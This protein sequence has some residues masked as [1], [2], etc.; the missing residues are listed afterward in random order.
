[1]I[2]KIPENAKYLIGVLKEKGFEAFVVGGC[3]R[4]CILGKPPKDW[5][6]CTSALPEQVMYCFQNH[7][8]IETG[9]KHGT[10]TIVIDKEPYEVTTYR[11]DGEYSDNRRPDS[12]SFTSSLI[13]DL[14]RRDF[15]INAMA[16]N[17]ESGLQ[18]PFGGSKDIAAGRIQCVGDADKR[19]Q[20]DALRIM[21]AVRFASQLEFEIAH[22]TQLAM[23]RNKSLLQKISVERIS[24]ELNKLLC[25]KGVANV[26]K[27]YPQIIGEAIPEIFPMVGFEQ[28]NPYHIYD[29]WGHTVT[30]IN[31][32][33]DDLVLRLT[34]F[35]HDIGKPDCFSVDSG[36]IG[37]FYGHEE[38]S[39]MI[40][41]EVMKRLRYNNQTIN[42]VVMLIKN[43]DIR[44]TV[45]RK[46]AKKML[47]KLGEEK[48]HL[49]TEVRIAD[50]T[51]QSQV[52]QDARVQKVDSFR[53]VIK[54]VMSQ[55]QC[56]SLTDLA[57]NGRDLIDL[58][59]GQGKSLGEI[60]HLLMNMVIEEEIDNDKP[61]LLSKA[62]TLMNEGQGK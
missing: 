23:V 33:R 27:E 4:D 59:I 31:N 56:F 35:F 57:I 55:N 52:N 12:V 60:L 6:I 11:I 50:V 32:I 41:H 46:F 8:V 16:F 29:V 38:K 42:D 20:E 58:G 1:M 49:L 28:K 61:T 25:G 43:H 34:M 7:Q 30:A 54:E 19:F 3:V 62:K 10:V 51:A 40:T 45:N 39:A 53:A 14:S 21:R 37:H 36:G 22:E 18:D 2:I 44:F 13:E 15:T 24:A 9:L 47:N 26:L 17:E 5:D 48:L